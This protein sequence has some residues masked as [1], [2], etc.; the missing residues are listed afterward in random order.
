[1]VVEVVVSISVLDWLLWNVGR[2]VSSA[3]RSNTSDDAPDDQTKD[4]QWDDTEEA[5]THKSNGTSGSGSLLWINLTVIVILLVF[6]L[7]CVSDVASFT[8]RTS[9]V[10]NTGGRTETKGRAFNTVTPSSGKKSFWI[11][12]L[13]EVEPG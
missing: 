12:V 1:L 3:S 9:T 11:S 4:D 2:G 13:S 5:D 7:I 8:T 10:V 6:I